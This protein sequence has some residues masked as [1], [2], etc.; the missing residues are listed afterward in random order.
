MRSSAIK[1]FLFCLC[2]SGLF[3]GAKAQDTTKL[4]ALEKNNK[5]FIVLPLRFTHLQNHNTMLS[6]IKAGR[7]IGPRLS[8]AISIYHSFYLKAFKSK[9]NLHGFDPQPRLF[10]NCMALEA[11][12]DFFSR[13]KMNANIQ[14]LTGWGF[15][16]YDLKEHEFESRQVNYLALEPSLNM[17][18][19]IAKATT[20]GLGVGYR[21]LYGRNAISYSSAVSNGEIPLNKQ[22]PNGLNILLNIK[23]YL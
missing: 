1:R 11:Q 16:K 14:L 17:D 20:L 2:I 5:W 23:G 19:R 22:F 3:T 18:F 10:I 8:A 7:Q 12:Y 15:V 9:A 6:G 4:T 13:K 21:P